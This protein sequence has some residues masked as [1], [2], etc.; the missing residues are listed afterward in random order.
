MQL[1]SRSNN[2]VFYVYIYGGNKVKACCCKFLVKDVHRAETQ[3]EGNFR[4]VCTIIV[5][6]LT[7]EKCVLCMFDR[8]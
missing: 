7:T 2:D 5:P 8:V 3:K 4:Y 1:G 6:L